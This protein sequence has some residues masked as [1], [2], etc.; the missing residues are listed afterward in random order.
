MF[1]RIDA[2]STSLQRV[3]AAM[4]ATEKAARNVLEQ[5]GD[6]GTNSAP[7]GS[8]AQV[9]HEQ[10]DQ[11]MRDIALV[12]LQQVQPQMIRAPSFVIAAANLWSAVRGRDAEL[13]AREVD[14]PDK[15][16]LLA[17]GLRLLKDDADKHLRPRGVRL[18]PS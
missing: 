15:R 10:H 7:D 1:D 13:F 8:P 5:P 11:A 9:D 4:S 6:P 14:L 12:Y 3:C 18:I 2:L 17:K 16:T